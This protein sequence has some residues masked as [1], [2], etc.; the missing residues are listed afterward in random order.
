MTHYPNRSSYIEW[1]RERMERFEAWNIPDGEWLRIEKLFLQTGSWRKWNAIEQE[2]LNMHL[3]DIENV[4]P[5]KWYSVTQRVDEL[6][7]DMNGI[8]GDRH[9]STSWVALPLRETHIYPKNAVIQQNRHVFAGTQWMLDNIHESM[10]IKSGITPE[11]LGWNMILWRKDGEACSL[12]WLP[13]GTDFQIYPEGTDPEEKNTEDLLVNLKLATQQEW[14]V[15]T[16]VNIARTLSDKSLKPRFK[17]RALHHRWS[18]LGVD[19]I[20]WEKMT[21]VSVKVWQTVLIGFPTGSVI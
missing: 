4:R 9:H 3:W 14:C 11:D 15:I 19:G 10:W 7:L 21:Q 6:L 1:E 8:V 2:L 13:I 18:L 20:V 12:D 5:W 16:W 17:E